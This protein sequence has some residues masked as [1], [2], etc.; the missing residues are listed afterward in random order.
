MCT[1]MAPLSPL[2]CDPAASGSCVQGRKLLAAAY[3][4]STARLSPI[5]A[6]KDLAHPKAPGDL[7]AERE[8]CA[9]DGI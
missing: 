1:A 5:A 4:S 2:P 6:V 7:S 9:V 3:P 8:P